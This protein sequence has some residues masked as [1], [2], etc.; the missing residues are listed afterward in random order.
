MGS[1][2]QLNHYVLFIYSF[3][4]L[5]ARQKVKVIRGLYGY[6]NSKQGKLYEHKGLIQTNSAK[7]LS[8]NVILVP[9]ENSF[10]FTNFFSLNKIIFEVKEAWLKE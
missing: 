3:K 8:Q 6:K 4:S 7:K 10:V 2:Q 5:S 1:K 9:I